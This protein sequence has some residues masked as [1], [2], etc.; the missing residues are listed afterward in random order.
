MI[1]FSGNYQYSIDDKGRLSV[2]FRFR[3]QIQSDGQ[4]LTVWVW[5][6]AKG[7]LRAYPEKQFNDLATSFE[8]VP[9][10]ESETALRDLMDNT[11]EC[12]IDKQG[13]IILSQ[14]FREETGIKREVVVVG[15]SRRFEIWDKARYK[16]YKDEVEPSIEGAFSAMQDK[17]NLI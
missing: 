9:G 6:H 8:G 4:A 11:E 14:K 10:K 12:P 7:Y 16:K 2:P 15:V 13:R 17:K 3:D 5:R 1:L